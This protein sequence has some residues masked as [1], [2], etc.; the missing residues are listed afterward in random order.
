M[1]TSTKTPEQLA[2]AVMRKLG[3]ID[4]TKEPT[5]IEQ[6]VIIDIYNDKIEE[7]FPRDKVFWDSD[8]IPRQVFG[9]MVRIV[10]EEFATI[11]G[12]DVPTEQDEDGKVISIGNRGLR[13]LTKIMARESADIPVK[14]A[15]F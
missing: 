5:A 11:Q 9:A 4:V 14:A 8:L 2:T 10:A 6:A 3:I 7:L 1:T 15:Y 13:M 12:K